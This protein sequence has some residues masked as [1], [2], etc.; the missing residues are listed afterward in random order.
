LSV[1]TVRTAA[2]V[3]RGVNG[4]ASVTPPP[5]QSIHEAA[6]YVRD[7]ARSAEFYRAI[8]GFEEIGRDP[9][10]HVF[11]RAGRD[12]LLLFDAETT[13]NPS[14][15]IPPHGATG[16]M[17]V[18]FET[19]ADGLDAWRSHLRSMGIPIEAEVEWPRGGRSL[20]IRDPDRHSIELVTR[21]IWGF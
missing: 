15:K 11:L 2:I 13:R 14:G 21:G 19:T 9:E 10:R 20:Y 3:A 5:V 8:F 6:L 4:G 12:V 18:A 17:H 7:L 16:E 1:L